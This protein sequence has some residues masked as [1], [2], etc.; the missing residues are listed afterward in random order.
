MWTMG[1]GC[2]QRKE[3]VVSQEATRWS[4]SFCTA[5]HDSMLGLHPGKSLQSNQDY[6]QTQDLDCFVLAP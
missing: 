4:S 2:M 6:L 5:S 1:V 3:L